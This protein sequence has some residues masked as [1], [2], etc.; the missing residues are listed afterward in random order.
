MQAGAVIGWRVIDEQVVRLVGVCGRTNT[1]CIY[2]IIVSYTAP[3]RY[4]SR[5]HAQHRVS[6]QHA[7]ESPSCVDGHRR[8]YILSGVFVTLLTG[9][10]T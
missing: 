6:Q 5:R 9:S 4:K 10:D 8:G 7:S 1:L 3:P 2:F